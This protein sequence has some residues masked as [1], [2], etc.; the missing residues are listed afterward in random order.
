MTS[1]TVTEEH[2]NEVIRH[3]SKK[4]GISSVPLKNKPGFILQVQGQ[5]HAHTNTHTHTHSRKIAA[6]GLGEFIFAMK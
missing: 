6:P 2:V 1:C 3:S 4:A 5:T